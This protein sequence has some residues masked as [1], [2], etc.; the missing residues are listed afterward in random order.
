MNVTLGW[1]K[2]HCSGY[3]ASTASQ[4]LQPLATWIIP[5]F[6]LL[7][8][9]SVGEDNRLFASRW[10]KAKEYVYLLGD[11]A[12]AICGG[13]AE[14]WM[15]SWLTTKLSKLK[16]SG[17]SF[18]EVAIGL[19]MLASQTEFKELTI[20]QPKAHNPVFSNTQNEHEAGES[21]VQ[22]LPKESISQV[23]G[24]RK[25]ESAAFMY[26][27]SDASGNPGSEVFEQLKR[28]I[29]TVLRARIDF[30][31]GIAVPVVLAIATTATVFH[32]AYLRLGDND[33]AHGLAFGIW[34]A[35]VIVL[36]VVSNSYVASVNPG[37][38]K[39]ALGDYLTLSSR[40]LPLRHRMRNIENWRVWVRD[41]LNERSSSGA[42][43]LL[44]LIGQIA[45][46]SIIAFFCAC[47][48]AISYNTP[49]IGIG[50][51]S[52]S[53][54]LYG[55]LVAVVAL[56]MVLQDWL[57][58]KN[59]T[60]PE[61]RMMRFLRSL[62]RLLVSFNAFVLC[63]STFAQVLGLYRSCICNHFGPPSTTIEL[64]IG[65]TMAVDNARKTWIPAGFVA[66]TFV[67]CVCGVAV[68]FRAYINFHIQGF[69]SE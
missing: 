6:T 4:W 22:V 45:A 64:A 56:V 1:C 47:A 16:G 39:A 40:T 32:D 33:T 15:D 5:P 11:P 68:G 42:Y 31:T 27:A 34:F 59:G 41:V 67:W 58:L 57:A 53:F 28:S 20:H 13:F 38:A 54:L 55:L 17:K 37:V 36:C 9:C 44:Y 49:T 48:A 63:F 30:V 52:F 23:E 46:A 65:T 50:C 62:Y 29:R 3:Q 14:L 51:R 21:V 7:L 8:L 35:W 43:Y 2:E 19:A 60:V 66:Y 10:Y 61:T 69:L 25:T 18:E 12:S 24:S 26:D